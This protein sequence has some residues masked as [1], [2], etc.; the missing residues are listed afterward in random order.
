MSKTSNNH[1][2]APQCAEFVRR[3]REAFGDIDVLYVKENDVELGEQSD[4]ES[5]TCFQL[6]FPV[7]R[8]KAA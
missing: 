2:Q 3:M 6:D 4:E 7:K 1:E 8:K 5:A